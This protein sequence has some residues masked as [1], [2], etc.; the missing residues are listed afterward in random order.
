MG[1]D[2]HMGVEVRRN[3]AWKLIKEEVFKN[4]WYDPNS[5]MEYFRNMKPFTNIP[6]SNRNYDLFAILADV[7]NGTGFAGV[8]TGEPFNFISEPKGYPDDISKE[9]RHDIEGEY[10][11]DGYDDSIPHLSNEHSASWLTLKELTDFDWTQIHRGY[12]CID[13]KTYREYVMKDIHPNSYCGDVGGGG[14]IKI[15]ETEMVD[16]INGKYPR[17]SDKKYYT[18]CYFSPETYKECAGGF[19]E[20]VIPVLVSLIPEGGADED[21]RIVFDFD[22]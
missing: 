12:G 16:L 15:N 9:L 8:K 10:N 21:V 20:D 1:I 3:G 5:N 13:E 18:Y 4:Y 11:E 14:V 6:Y 19:Y 17:Q 2:I 22:S 7:R